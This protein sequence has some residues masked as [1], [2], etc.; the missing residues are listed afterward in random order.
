MIR[1]FLVVTLR[2]LK[3]NALYSTINIVG[4][5]V[6]IVCSI[7]ILLWV[8]HE[9]SFDTFYP[10]A[11][12]LYQ[13]WVNAE[14]DGRVNSWRSV[15]L[16]T[17]EALKS[18]NANIANTSV[19][20]WG[21]KHLLTVGETRITKESY[22]VS[23]EFLE[24]FG[25]DLESGDPASVLDDPNSIVLTRS[26][27]DILFPGQEAI[28]QFVKV[29]NAHTLKVT[30]ILKDIPSNSTFTFDFLMTYKH[31]QSASEWV[32]S[33]KSNWGNYSFQVYVELHDPAKFEET[34]AAI[35]GLLTENGE[36]DM[37][38][39]LFLHPTLKWRLFSNFVNGKA[40]SGMNDYVQLFSLI[41]IFILI[42]ACIN[43]M[44][45]ATAR[46]EKRA[47]EVGIRKSMGSH[48]SQL[49]AQFIG[50]SL[51]ISLI[52]M[53]IAI[54]ITELALPSYNLLVEK[55]LSID[56][57][58]LI[59][60][61]LLVG[62]VFFTGIVSGSYP[63]FY[64]SSFNP[65][66]TLKGS[67]VAGK[68][69]TTPRKV[70]VVVQFTFSI[71]LMIATVV[72]Y[73]QIELVKNREIGYNQSNLITV[74]ITED[75][76]KSYKALKQELLQSG[77]VESV[78]MSNSPITSIHS[79]NFLGWPGKPETEK[80]IFTTISTE[81]DY[82][83]TMGIKVLEGRDF[84]EEFA[85]D[86]N[87]ILI[88]KAA[89]ELMK[90][91]DP[92]GTQL[93]LWGGKRTLIGVVDNVLMGS[94]YDPIKPMFAI[95]DP[96]WISVI[97]VRLN[98]GTAS[99]RLETVAG[100]FEKYNPAYPFEFTFADADYQK[101]FVTIN[102]TRKL[103]MLFCFLAILITGLGL[104]GLASY[105]AEQKKKEIGIRKVLGASTT[106]L[107]VLI[108]KDFAF[109]VIVSFM[110]AAPVAWYLLD[111]YLERYAVRITIQWWIFPIVG[112][113]ALTFAISIVANLARKASQS[114][115]VNAL[116]NE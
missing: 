24:M 86:S 80:V 34:Q 95:L 96:G 20:N 31:W 23:E 50:E 77:A 6:G 22:Y 83:K 75:L 11:D 16:P 87:S 56:Y 113:V 108:S 102:M 64:L 109:F 69:S 3:R 101:K 85:T 43:F 103:G 79:N 60:W 55:D 91:E 1:N 37:P 5:S 68:G 7:L 53:L 82:A 8:R 26:L 12:R 46:S 44:N 115:P 40:E 19:M 29:N 72:I 35:S 107:V 58:A 67:I 41:A 110:I 116:R 4:L 54:L 88:N 97:T 105:T 38:R 66:K 14:F 32:V 18:A 74:E 90:L 13:L 25:F 84:S 89:L 71:F 49:I 30:G 98:P 9:T 33:N 52:A 111:Q 94:P 48:R 76:R 93:D 47:R 81:Y 57:S 104:F 45:L 10:K 112:I 100:I 59:V 114:N 92:I 65:V 21:E 73:Q 106:N 70:L 61:L 27:A 51:F 78:T 63:A 42:M 28:G 36:D 99:E 15:P 2:S 17:Y 39:F 62:I